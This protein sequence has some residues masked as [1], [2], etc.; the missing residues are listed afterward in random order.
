MGKRASTWDYFGRKLC[1][2]G[3]KIGGGS[4]NQSPDGPASV[5]TLR[6]RGTGL[7]S[8]RKLGMVKLSGRS[9]TDIVL[10]F[11]RPVPIDTCGARP[12]G[13]AFLDSESYPVSAHLVTRRLK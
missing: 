10:A 7:I 11:I 12:F 1:S 8:E 6:T 5:R 2:C 13:V 4:W 3:N 9:V